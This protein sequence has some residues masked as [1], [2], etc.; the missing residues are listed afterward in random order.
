MLCFLQLWPGTVRLLCPE[1]VTAGPFLCRANTQEASAN[2]PDF[3]EDEDPFGPLDDALGGDA[4]HEA[5]EAWTIEHGNAA[6]PDTSPEAQGRR[7]AKLAARLRRARDVQK[8]QFAMIDAEIAELEDQLAA[9]KH[10]RLQV[11]RWFL[12]RTN[13]E[14]YQ[15]RFWHDTADL[16]QGSAQKSFALSH[17]LT[18]GSRR[19]PERVK[20]DAPVE[21]LLEYLPDECFDYKTT[22]R[23]AEANKLVEVRDGVAFVA[24]TGEAIWG[25]VVE[26]TPG[27][28]EVF[29][30]EGAGH[31]K[32]TLTAEL[33]GEDAGGE[34]DGDNDQ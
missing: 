4:T 25:A 8:M 34:T 14:R 26:T 5:H 32:I 9:A 27:F 30:T 28:T 24:E 29:V 10:R 31:E 2:M 11:D 16:F 3:R 6:D 18:I 17:G 22:V 21:A 20:W 13:F 19:V 7:A 15:L 1:S 12:D 23:K 33:A